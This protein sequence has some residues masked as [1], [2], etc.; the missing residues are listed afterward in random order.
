MLL[1]AGGSPHLCDFGHAR[2]CPDSELQTGLIM[3]A[4]YRAP[5]VLLDMQWDF[6]VDLWSIGML[7]R[8]FLLLLFFYALL[9]G[10]STQC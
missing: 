10:I 8:P 9:H 4:Q 3:P 6:A 2:I 1:A 7:V 5:E